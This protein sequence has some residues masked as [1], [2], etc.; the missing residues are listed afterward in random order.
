MRCM[1][2]I[3][4]W[5]FFNSKQCDSEDLN[6]QVRYFYETANRLKTCF[7]HCLFKIKNVLFRTYCSY[8]FARQLWKNFVFSLKSVRIT[9]NNS[10]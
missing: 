1:N 9:Y 8:I 6:R 10:F 5:V 3:I 2:E 7:H 4:P